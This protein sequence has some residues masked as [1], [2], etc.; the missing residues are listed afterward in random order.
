[1]TEKSSLDRENKLWLFMTSEEERRYVDEVYARVIR[2]PR[3][4]LDNLEKL[5][6]F[7]TRFKRYKPYEDYDEKV[8]KHFH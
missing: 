3:F 8:F 6:M 7:R 4:Y 1:M 5:D 2:N